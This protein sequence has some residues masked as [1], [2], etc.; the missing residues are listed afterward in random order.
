MAVEGR[1]PFRRAIIA[2]AHCIVTSIWLVLTGRIHQPRDRVGIR[3]RFADGSA[4]DI[5]RET[6]VDASAPAEPVVLIVEFRLRAV[7]GFSHRIFR[8]ESLLNTPLFVGFEGF[9]SK[10]WLAHDGNEVY[11]GIYEWDGAQA[12]NSYVGA[13]KWILGL[14]CV[15]GSIH[16]WVVGHSNRDQW[17]AQTGELVRSAAIDNAEWWRVVGKTTAASPQVS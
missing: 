14:V 12:A 9:V 8:W 1:L 17:L 11:R 4:A 10:L 5:Y 7:H 15:P 13:L 6:V 2:I 16:H 3:L